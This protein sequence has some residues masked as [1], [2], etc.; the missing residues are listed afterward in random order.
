MQNQDIK[1]TVEMI[2]NSEH[3]ELYEKYTKQKSHDYYDNLIKYE[4]ASYGY[5][6]DILCN[7]PQTTVRK[8]VISSDIRYAP[9]CF[10]GT[11]IL[12]EHIAGELVDNR[13]SKTPEILSV[14]EWFINLDLEQLNITLN[15]LN[16][17]KYKTIKLLYQ[18]EK[19]VPTTIEK[20]MT[21]IQLYKAHNPL[22]TCNI[23]VK[24]IKL[25][26]ELELITNNDDDI[27]EYLQ[28]CKNSMTPYNAY[29]KQLL[30]YKNL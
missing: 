2:Q 19:M 24:T 20:T 5:C 7:N 25:L 6:H 10:D 18:A 21:P 23:D 16:K 29:H 30:K 3:R 13:L 14:Y 11:R 9:Q 1:L 12:W 4:L 27:A 22:W 17:T 8:H 28:D 15:N 26:Y